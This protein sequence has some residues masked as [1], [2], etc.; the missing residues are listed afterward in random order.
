MCLYEQG[1]A[2]KLLSRCRLFK[3][4]CM[5]SRSLCANR[6]TRMRACSCLRSQQPLRPLLLRPRLL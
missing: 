5:W 3:M 1:D 2:V 4:L 6:R